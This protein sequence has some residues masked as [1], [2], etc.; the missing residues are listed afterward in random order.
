MFD[1]ASK[2]CYYEVVAEEAIKLY[3]LFWRN[4]T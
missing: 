1:M 3:L 4:Y 2:E